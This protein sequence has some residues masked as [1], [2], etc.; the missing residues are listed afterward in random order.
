MINSLTPA[1]RNSFEL[2]V[3][4]YLKGKWGD[5]RL[6]YLYLYHSLCEALKHKGHQD[7]PTKTLLNYMKKFDFVAPADWKN[8][9]P[10]TSK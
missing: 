4:N 7:G 6:K 9:R 10:L 5:S 2:G 1:F 3:N 8:F